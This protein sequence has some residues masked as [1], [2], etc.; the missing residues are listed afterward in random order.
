MALI[1]FD[2]YPKIPIIQGRLSIYVSI[3]VSEFYFLGACFSK[4]M[5]LEG[6]VNC[7]NSLNVFPEILNPLNFGKFSPS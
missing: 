1:Y 2:P 7:T 5:D 6:G 4:M 3:N